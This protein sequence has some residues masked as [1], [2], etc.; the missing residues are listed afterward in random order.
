MI[1]EG[2]DMNFLSDKR[3]RKT[4]IITT[5]V[6][7]A[8]AIIVG[9][10]AI[11]LGDYYRADN[12]AIGAFLPEGTTWKEEPD[13]T[14]IFE[15]KGATKGL[16]FYPGGKVEHT[17]YVP[18][19]QA[20]AEKGILCVLIEMPFNLAVFDINAADGIQKEYPEIEDWYIG[21]HSLGGSMAAY[22][23]ADHAEDYKGLILLASYSTADLS[24]TDVAVLSV[25]GSEDT[26]MNREKYIEN[27]SNLPSDFTEYV[28]DG[29]CHAYFGMYGAQDGDGTPTITNEAQIRLT[30][31][32]I[33]KL[34]GEE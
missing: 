11:Y 20:C 21:G 4:F 26:V 29:G 5:S 17:A 23:L 25:F 27:K 6:V 28:I 18:L 3:R 10:C 32:N 34:M 33:V 1:F 22:Y 2:A 8:V 12:E 14:V 16:I 9:A 15:P 24:A 30:V 19:M 31:E 13:G 7:L